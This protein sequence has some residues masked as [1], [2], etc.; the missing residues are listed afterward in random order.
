MVARMAVREVHVKGAS[1]ERIEW[2]VWDETALGSEMTIGVSMASVGA[3]F[4]E[5]SAWPAMGQHR[6]GLGART[7][8]G[9]TQ[10][11]LEGIGDK[12]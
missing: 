1:T 4:R 6:H 8:P 5:F 7:F 3:H 12:T 2:A 10:N 9:R 11:G